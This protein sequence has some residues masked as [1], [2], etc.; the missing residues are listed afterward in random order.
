MH[1]TSLGT[2]IGSTGINVWVTP[3]VQLDG[4]YNRYDF[5]TNG[6]WESRHGEINWDYFMSD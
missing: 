2:V 6:L 3:A 5:S 1:L 4:I